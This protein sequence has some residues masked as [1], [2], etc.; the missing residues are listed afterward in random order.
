MK[1]A[2]YGGHNGEIRMMKDLLEDH[3]VVL[4][5]NSFY[6]DPLVKSRNEDLVIS[7]FPYRDISLHDDKPLIIYATNP[8]PSIDI[9]NIVKKRSNV[10][11]VKDIDNCYPY[12]SFPVDTDISISHSIK[13]DRIPPYIGDVNTIAIVNRRPYFRWQKLTTGIFKRDVPLEEYLSGI[14]YVVYHIPDDTEFF[15]SVSH[16]KAVFYFSDNPYTLIMYELMTMGMPM[17]GFY[18]SW[19]EPKPIKKYLTHYGTNTELVNT[20]LRNLLSMPAKRADYN[21]VPFHK[22]KSQWN[23]LLKRY[24]KK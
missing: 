4:Y 16:H 15:R 1:I 17:V 21:F 5:D 2:L 10:T 22:A 9:F 6:I 13:P 24:E 14:P 11:V 3:E 8:F 7:L 19:V 20:M 12:E 23:D 18:H